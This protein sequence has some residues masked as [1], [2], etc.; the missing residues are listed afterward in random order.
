MSYAVKEMF[1]SLQGEGRQTGRAAVFV[2]FA[3]CNLWSGQERHRA[4]AICRFCDT[5]F[6]GVDGTHGG[7]HDVAALA[8]RA[9]ALWPA[10]EGTPLVICTG[11][12]PALQ[13]DVDLVDALHEAGFEV[14]VETNGTRELPPGLDWVCVS[15]KA[16]TDLVTVVGDELKV[17]HPQP[18]LDLAWLE[19]LD[20]RFR[21]LQPLDGPEVAAN[22]EACVGH[23]L[24][25]PG[26]LLS[27]QTHKILGIR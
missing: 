17:V 23:C 18:G 19:T 7:R 9:A 27:L 24:E 1:F 3:G 11:G 4:S 13:L 26:W 22:L 21:S 25:H 10:A 6:A 5:D 2:R 20:F 14:A 12:E 16:G 15:P 8:D